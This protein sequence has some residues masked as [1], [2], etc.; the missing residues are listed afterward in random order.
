MTPS[1]HAPGTVHGFFSDVRRWERV[2]THLVW[3]EGALVVYCAFVW[4][5]GVGLGMLGNMLTMGHAPA[6]RALAWCIAGFTAWTA[7]PPLQL[8]IP[9]PAARRALR[10]S[11]S[12]LSIG[13][14]AAA[15][16]LLHGIGP[17]TGH[18]VFTDFLL[19]IT[20]PA[21]GLIALGIAGLAALLRPD[22]RHP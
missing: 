4:T 14:G 7:L 9:R 19:T 17:T 1:A 13:A 20:L 3:S 6:S 11:T 5:I 22:A 8:V 18:P 15:L 16:G 12:I 10:A 21:A 2:D